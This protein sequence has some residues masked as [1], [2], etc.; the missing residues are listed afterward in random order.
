MRRTA[1]TRPPTPR[2][3]PPI[4]L[5]AIRAKRLVRRGGIVATFAGLTLSG[6]AHQPSPASAAPRIADG[7]PPVPAT[8]PHYMPDSLFTALGTVRRDSAD[9]LK[10][11]RS[12]VKVAFKDGAAQRERQQ[13]IDSIGGLVVGGFRLDTDGEYFVRIPGSTYADIQAAVA[14]LKALPQVEYAFPFIVFFKFGPG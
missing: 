4:R 13:A 2:C 1:T 14:K 12:I 11:V 9:V 10:M 8:A 6:C 3:V 5:I 7:A